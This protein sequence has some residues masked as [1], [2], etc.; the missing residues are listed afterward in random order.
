MAFVQDIREDVIFP[1]IGMLCLILSACQS[2]FVNSTSSTSSSSNPEVSSTVTSSKTANIP[3]KFTITTQGIGHGR[4][5]MTYGQ[6]KAKLGQGAQFQIKVP[7]IV[8]F[9]AIAVYQSGQVQYYILYPAGQTL[10]DTDRIEALLTDNYN[11]RTVEGIGPGMSLI[12]AEKVYGKATLSYNI[13]TESREYV[14]FTNQP[15]S[16]IYFR[17][18]AGKEEFAGIYTKPAQEY[19]E[20]TIFQDRAIIRSVEVIKESRK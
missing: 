18:I 6:L 5:G 15:F 7:F 16:N 20:T 2:P 9:D 4:I 10:K 1:S 12:Q 11:Y 3:A 19:N 17:P 14:R 13:N 8:D